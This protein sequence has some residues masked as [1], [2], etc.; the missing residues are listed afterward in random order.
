MRIIS[1]KYKGRKL[2]IPSNLDI[3]PTQDRVKESI[4]SVLGFQLEQKKILDLF[5]GSGSLGLEALS[6][7]ADRVCFVDKSIEAIKLI[8]HNIEHSRH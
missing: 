4:F 5:A 7:G 1:G 3:R 8:K 2:K 6:R